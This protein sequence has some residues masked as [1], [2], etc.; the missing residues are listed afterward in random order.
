[1]PEEKPPTAPISIPG[2]TS[3]QAILSPPNSIATNLSYSSSVDYPVPTTPLGM[4]GVN[5]SSTPQGL[6]NPFASP[7]THTGLTYWSPPRTQPLSDSPTTSTAFSKNTTYLFD[8]TSPV[9][10]SPEKI[11]SLKVGSSPPR[12]TFTEDGFAMG[13]SQD[14]DGEVGAFVRLCQEAPPLRLTTPV[15]STVASYD[16]DLK[17]FH[18]LNENFQL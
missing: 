14:E 9:F 13:S 15:S 18:K 5:I 11:D 10:N 3:P 12:H 7:V 17:K 8:E 2:H 1:M 6:S 16:E 4:R